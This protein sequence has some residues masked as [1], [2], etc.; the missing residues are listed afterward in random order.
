MAAILSPAHG[1]AQCGCGMLQAGRRL[2]DSMATPT[3]LE[4][5]LLQMKKAFPSETGTV[6][7]RSS[8]SFSKTPIRPLGSHTIADEN[9]D[10]IEASVLQR[11]DSSTEPASC[12]ESLLGSFRRVL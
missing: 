7:C 6:S 11:R 10:F 3:L 8:T 4:S 12:R 2:S 1:T 9:S 5:A